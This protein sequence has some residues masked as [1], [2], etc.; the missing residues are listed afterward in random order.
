MSAQTGPTNPGPTCPACGNDMHFQTYRKI[1]G[2]AGD[3][4]R[5][6]WVCRNDYCERDEEVELR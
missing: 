3:H 1:R 4:D 5:G 6:R 2:Y